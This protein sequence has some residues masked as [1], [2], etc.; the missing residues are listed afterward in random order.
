MLAPIPRRTLTAV[1]ALFVLAAWAAPASALVP[2]GD[3]SS[4]SKCQSKQA[5]YSPVGGWAGT[6]D[7]VFDGRLRWDLC[8]VRTSS[9]SHYAIAR[10]SAPADLVE[11]FDRFTGLVDV[12]L[13]KCVNG[14]YTTVTQTAWE[15]EGHEVATKIGSRYYFRWLQTPS[16]TSSASTYRVRTRGYGA[17]VP[18]NGGWYFSLIDGPYPYYGAGPG[19]TTSGCLTP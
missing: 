16:T 14:V 11:R 12:F 18:R 4:Y 3:P 15:V 17:V 19:I 10:L 7:W 6:E 5:G 13:Q 1:V 9:G 2:P 8:V